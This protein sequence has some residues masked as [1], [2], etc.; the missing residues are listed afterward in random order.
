MK[1]IEL[2]KTYSLDL[3]SGSSPVIVKTIKYTLNGVSCKYD[4]GRVEQ[5]SYDLFEMNGFSRN[6]KT[7]LDIIMNN[8]P[9]EDILSAEGFD[10]AILGVVVDHNSEPRLAYSFLKCIEI[11]INHNE[12]LVV[13][14]EEYF[15]N[16]VISAYV[17]G[18]SPIWIN[19]YI[20]FE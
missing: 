16:N 17:G 11:L 15:N 3:G 19:D 20:F 7:K 1:R 18:N 14:A 12:M 5:I 9:D 4:N 10:D 8:Y 13:D 6:V 2:Y